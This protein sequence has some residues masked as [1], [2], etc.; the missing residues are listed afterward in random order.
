MID[1]L[2]ECIVQHGEYNQYFVIT[3][4]EMQ[5]LKIVLKFFFKMPLK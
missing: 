3:V 4:N 1:R 5:A 2:Q